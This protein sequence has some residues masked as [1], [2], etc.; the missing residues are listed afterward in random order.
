LKGNTNSIGGLLA[1]LSLPV[2]AILILALMETF[3]ALRAGF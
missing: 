3:R 2:G 1:G